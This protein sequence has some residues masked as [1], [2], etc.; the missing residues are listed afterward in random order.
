MAV[1]PG[2]NRLDF[3][4]PGKVSCL[5]GVIRHAMFVPFD[6]ALF[7]SCCGPIPIGFHRGVLGVHG[8]V[9]GHTGYVVGV[10]VQMMGQEG[11]FLVWRICVTVVAG[12]AALS[13]GQGD[14]TAADLMVCC[15]MAIMAL[16]TQPPHVDIATA[17]VKIENGVEFAVPD[18]VLVTT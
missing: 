15:L 11:F 9:T 10:F 1:V 5:P 12:S 14:T 7:V 4:T 8:V 18:K 16:K 6:F 3:T 13:H 2:I 17:A